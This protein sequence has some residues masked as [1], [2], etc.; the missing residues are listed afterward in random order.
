MLRA[1]LAGAAITMAMT[2]FLLGLR[3]NRCG[4][5]CQGGNGYQQAT[6][7]FLSRKIAHTRH[8]CNQ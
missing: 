8:I 6:H 7:G 1:T 2:M 5:Q 4:D 3:E